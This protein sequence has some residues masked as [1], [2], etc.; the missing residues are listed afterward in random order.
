MSLP[1]P[2]PGLVICYNYLWAEDANAGREEGDKQRPAAIIMTADQSGAGRSN[3][4]TRV[5]VLPITHSAPVNAA[6]AVEIPA[7]VCRAAG[8]DAA[9]TWIVLSEFNEFVWPGFDLT[10]IPGRIPRTFAYGFLTPGFF[11]SVRDQWLALD[12]AGK[13][14]SISRDE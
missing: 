7:Q 5:Y 6:A 9:R 10:G 12:A 2:L 8:L 11:S 13:S 4:E 1:K 14:Q 3:D